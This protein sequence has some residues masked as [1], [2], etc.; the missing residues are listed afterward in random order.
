MRSTG[1]ETVIIWWVLTLA[2]WVGI[3]VGIVYSVRRFLR[4][5]EHRTAAIGR[6]DALEL[7]LARLEAQ[8]AAGEP[9]HSLASRAT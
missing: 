4:A 3:P 9:H 6:V 7:R 2:I 8:L 5:Y 1:F